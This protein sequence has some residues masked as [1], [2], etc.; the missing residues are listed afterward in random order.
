MIPRNL[1]SEGFFE[2]PLPYE[3]GAQKRNPDIYGGVGSNQ[4][5]DTQQRV[6][7]ESQQ[8]PH[9]RASP[10]EMPEPHLIEEWMH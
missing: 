5:Q 9:V 3:R 4:M 2:L 8:A 7:Q 10:N 6:A 1:T